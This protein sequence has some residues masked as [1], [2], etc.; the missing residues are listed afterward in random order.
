[1][2]DLASGREELLDELS[3]EMDESEAFE[4]EVPSFG[5]TEE[6]LAA[7]L[8]EATSDEELDHFFGGL[9][10]GAKRLLKSP[11]GKML[12]GAL[13]GIAKK[14]L[15]LAG[16]TLGNMFVPGLGGAVGGQL[17][18]MLGNAFEGEGLSEDEVQLEVAKRVVR[19]ARQA[20]AQVAR[21]PRAIS[22]ARA[23]VQSGLGT[24]L[25]RN[26]PGLLN[27]GPLGASTRNSGRWYRRGNR[28]IIVGA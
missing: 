10:K 2:H 5:E 19:T 1:M 7:E 9:M 12:G 15:P 25:K 6:E 13:R 14:A 17:G 20:A 21:D 18:G 28:I 8:L 24:A 23:A 22:D 27:A 3:D 4:G 16:K 11:A 26:L